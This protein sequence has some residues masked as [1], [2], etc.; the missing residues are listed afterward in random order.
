ME[1][2]IKAAQLITSLAILVVL[3]EFGHYLAARMFKIKVEKF[4]LFFNPYFSLYKKKIGDTEW[5][6]GWLPLGGYVK[7]AGMIDESMDKEQMAKPPQPWEFRSKPAWQRLIVMIGGVVVNLIVGIVI[8][9]FLMFSNGEDKL[10]T[11]DLQDGL[12]IHPYLEQFDLKSGDN[13]LEMDGQPIADYRDINTAILLK[14]VTDL[15][16]KKSSGEVIA[17][18][19]PDNIEYKVFEEGAIPIVRLRSKS[20]KIERITAVKNQKSLEIKTGDVLIAINGKNIDS[21]RYS[22]DDITFKESNR[23]TLNRAGEELNLTL[24]KQNIDTLLSVYPVFAAGLKCGDEFTSIDGKEITYFDD[25]VVALYHKKSKPAKVEIKRNGESL[26]KTVEVSEVGTMGYLANA[27]QP[28]DLD[29]I[30]H[31]DYSFGESISVGW[32]K[33]FNTLGN[34]VGQMKF[35]FTS[36]GAQSIGGFASMGK[37]FAPTWDWQVFWSTTALI[38]IILAFMNILPIPALDG[39]HV[40][41]LLYEMIRGKEAPQKILEYAQYVGILFFIALMLYANGN[42]IIKYFFN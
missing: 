26:L 31:F 2:F 6:I 22:I 42:D 39:G 10:A 5:G 23:V 15:K 21:L 8:Y 11:K 25:I 37:L 29:A 35:L 18:K 9:I 41:F 36:K 32:D 20:T 16:V 28:V 38:S 12:F 33:G 19:L 3:H 1:F 17:V 27:V 34:Y 30:V 13:I 7:I 14:N 24:D 40:V 4:Y